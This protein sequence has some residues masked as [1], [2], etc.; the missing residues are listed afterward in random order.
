MLKFIIYRTRLQMESLDTRLF[1]PFT[2][3]IISNFLGSFLII[4]FNLHIVFFF[5]IRNH[6]PIIEQLVLTLAYIHLAYSITAP[7]EAL[8]V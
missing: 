8:I 2:V 7:V 3:Q 6:A 4:V 5:L 1:I